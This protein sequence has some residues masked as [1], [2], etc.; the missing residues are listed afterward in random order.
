MDITLQ[1]PLGEPPLLSASRAGHGDVITLCLQK[2]NA[3]AS[4]AA[5][6]GETALHWLV[7]FDDEYIEPIAK[8]MIARGATIN[9]VTRERVTHSVYPGYVDVDFQLP[10]TPLTR[11]AH[12]NRPYVV[13]TRLA[14]GADPSF[15]PKGANL[16]ALRTAVYYHHYEC[17]KAIIE[18]LESKVTQTTSDGNIDKR[19]ALMY[20]PVAT[21]AERAANKFSIILRGEGD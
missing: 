9:A 14:H 21:E 13:R 1:N 7:R 17:L 16:G 5:K 10:G 8:D 4:L 20:G 12:H 11:A 15:V 2:V 3:N 19:S 6:N 18:H